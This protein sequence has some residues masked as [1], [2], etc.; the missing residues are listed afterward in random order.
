MYDLSYVLTTTW[1]ITWDY[2]LCFLST[3]FKAVETFIPPTNRSLLIRRD[4]LRKVRTN[5]L[6]YNRRATIIELAVERVIVTRVY[7][8]MSSVAENINHF[9]V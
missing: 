3:R 1:F 6:C 7:I 4:S 8:K 9:L 2:E 5:V